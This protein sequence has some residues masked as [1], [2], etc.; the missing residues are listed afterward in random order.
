MKIRFMCPFL[1]FLYVFT[2][3]VGLNYNLHYLKK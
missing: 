1:L 2:Q 3:T